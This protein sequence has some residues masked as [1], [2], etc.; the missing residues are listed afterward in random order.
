MPR[1]KILEE[2]IEVGIVLDKRQYE[3]LKNFS[4]K[5]GVSMSALVRM[6]I[7]RYINNLNS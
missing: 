6:L 2:K 5:H 4:Q 7:E 1:T 3:A